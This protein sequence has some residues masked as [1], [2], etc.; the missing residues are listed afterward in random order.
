MTKDDLMK[1]C[2]KDE[3]R[4]GLASPWSVGEHTVGTNG[5]LLIRVPR[6]PD[7]PESPDAPKIGRGVFPL[8]QP[9]QWY[10][11]PEFTLPGAA[12]EECGF[13]FGSGRYPEKSAAKC[14]ECDG[15]GK[16]FNRDAFVQ[17]GSA[18][19]RLEPLDLLRS[20]PNCEIGPVGKELPAWLRFDV[21]DGLLMPC[22]RRER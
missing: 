9:E 1:F 10:P 11:I 17:I 21:G 3:Y 6:L 18:R 13:C 20:L 2:S 12:E 16:I 22:R 4:I 8:V 19:F 7:V 5:H 14:P 15:T